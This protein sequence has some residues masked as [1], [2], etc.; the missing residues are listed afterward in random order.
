MHNARTCLAALEGVEDLETRRSLRAAALKYR[1][2]AQMKMREA[3]RDTG[4]AA[5]LTADGEISGFN[6]RHTDAQ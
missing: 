4:R 5:P 3:S 6:M 1:A 2:L